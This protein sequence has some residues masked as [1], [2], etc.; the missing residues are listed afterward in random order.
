MPDE[1]QTRLTQDSSMRRFR[2]YVAAGIA[3][4]IVLGTVIMMIIALQVTANSESPEQFAQVKDLLLIINPL[5]GVVLGYYF[6]KVSTEARAENAE[7]TAHNAVITAQEAAKTRDEALGEAQQ[8]KVKTEKAEADLETTQQKAAEM[9]GALTDMTQA[10]EKLMGQ[11]SALE[12]TA[13]G[14]RGLESEPSDDVYRELRAA[15]QHAH[16]VIGSA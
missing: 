4:V 13:F 12:M 16:R 5:L 14:P 1:Q 2:E 10:A 8:A 11:S 3:I 6:N 9:K 15:L 7:A